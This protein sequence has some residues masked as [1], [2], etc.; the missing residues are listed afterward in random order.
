M[1]NDQ[2]RRELD[3][4]IANSSASYAAI[5]RMIQRNPAYIQQYIK[6]GTPEY[7]EE[8]DRRLIAEFFGVD[9][10]LLGKPPS[11]FSNQTM[12]MV[13]KLDVQ[14]SAGLGSALGGEITLS[15]YGFNRRW[16][17]DISSGKPEKL[18]IV[19]VRGDSMVP[20]LV[21]GDDILVEQ[22][23]GGILRDGIYVL[24]RDD[25]LLVKRIAL[26]PAS[27][28]LTIVSD[29]PAYPSWNDCDSNDLRIVGRVIWTGRKLG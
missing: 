4:L 10:V 7:L 15:H 19:R 12:V 3:R 26:G 18:S 23:D 13:P 11:D 1:E 21:D 9:E 28:K 20:T 8:R 6:R 5:S 16:L 17:R 27:G 29:N 24:Q 25:S 22:I 2:P 14:A